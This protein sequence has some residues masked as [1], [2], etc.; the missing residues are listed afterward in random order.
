MVALAHD[1]LDYALFTGEPLAL[2]LRTLERG[3]KKSRVSEHKR[4][5][6]SVCVCV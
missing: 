6:V 3:N 4:K 1:G 5:R 2:L